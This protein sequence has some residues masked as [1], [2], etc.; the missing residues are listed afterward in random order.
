[1]IFSREAFPHLSGPDGQP[2]RRHDDCIKAV[3]QCIGN[4]VRE[5]QGSLLNKFRGDGGLCSGVT[6]GV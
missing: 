3:M 4:V 1:M 6:V 2:E 5:K